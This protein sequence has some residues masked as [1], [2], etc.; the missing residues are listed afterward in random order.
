M[1]L[2]VFYAIIILSYTPFG[3]MQMYLIASNMLFMRNLHKKR[4]KK[5][6][7]KNNVIVVT[8]TNGA[9][10]DVVEK[11]I[12]TVDGY[13]LGV[14]QFVIKEERDKFKYSCEEIVVPS[15]Y[16]C[17]DHSRNKMRALHYGIMS[18]HKKGY[19]K[20][21]YICHLDDDSI[22]TKKYLEYII[23][24]MTEEGGQGT[25]RLR[26]FGHHII[27][28]L[29]DMIRI[30][31]CEAWCKHYNI[32][33]N[34]KFVHGEG[35]TI[36]ADV[37]YEIGWDYSTYGAEDLIMGLEISKRYKFGYIPMG[38]INIAPPTSMK[39]YYKQRRRWFW[40]IFK[41][42]GKVEKLDRATFMFYMYMYIVGITGII[43][44]ILL[45]YSLIVRPALPLILT[46]FW[47]FNTIAFF[48]YYQFGSM[49]HGSKSQSLLLFIFQFPIA[50]YD[51][52]TIIYSLLVR[53]DFN[54]FETI[55]KV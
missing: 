11:I 13:G 55:K 45:P 5:L 1:F 18:L 7:K 22:V 15:K 6:K 28:S 53:P 30:S 40:S 20:E 35:L 8:T 24:Y 2:Q 37:E 47:I 23:N 32:S 14:K 38:H 46:P 50:F 16:V 48:L 33:N 39:D 36:R 27:S 10:T 25:I 3:I 29:S 41:N 34:P 52:L 31:N 17:P 4:Y 42:D 51:G 43:G 44:F 49:H 21:T 12:A 9:A 26:E 19:G 54:T